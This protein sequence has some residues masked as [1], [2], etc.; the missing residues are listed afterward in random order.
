M[1]RQEGRRT[2]L[3]FLDA[4]E[5]VLMKVGK[6]LRPLE[7]VEHALELGLLRSKG[8]TPEQTMK[9]KL[10][11]DVLEKK[12]GSRFMRTDPNAFGLRTW[13]HLTE[14]MADRFQKALLEAD[15]V[16]FDAGVLR[17]FFPV[18]GITVLDLERGWD[19]VAQT[20]PMQRTEA[21][22]TYDVIQLF[23]QSHVDRHPSTL[24]RTA[25]LRTSFSA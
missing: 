17:D 22:E 14:Y 1:E 4:A 18:D 5:K 20:F 23:S 9:A 10:S 6:P 16:V 13:S 3:S 21:E 8:Q 11:T 2:I 19:L 15:I 7:I 24:H 12:L 25:Q